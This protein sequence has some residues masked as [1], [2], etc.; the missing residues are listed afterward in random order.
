VIFTSR[1][2]NEFNPAQINWTDSGELLCDSFRLLLNCQRKVYGTEARLHVVCIPANTMHVD[3]SFTPLQFL[4]LAHRCI[5]MHIPTL[6]VSACQRLQLKRVGV[7]GTRPTMSTGAQ[8]FYKSTFERCADITLVFPS[9]DDKRVVHSL[10]IDKLTQSASEI[11]LPNAKILV[12]VIQRML[13]R[14]KLDAVILA[15]TE[16]PLLLQNYSQDLNVR[17]LDTNQIVIDSV[18]KLVNK[19]K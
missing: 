5:A 18:C 17:L 14:S 8:G 9:I 6:V 1:S 7:C 12:G 13:S 10:I 16:L 11:N 4:A 19:L 3:E 2:F 15:C